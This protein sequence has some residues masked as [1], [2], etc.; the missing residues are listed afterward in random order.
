[1]KLTLEVYSTSAGDAGGAPS[2]GVRIRDR[3][4]LEAGALYDPLDVNFLVDNEFLPAPETVAV[5]IYRPSEGGEDALVATTAGSA[6]APVPGHSMMR[7][8]ALATSTPGFDSWYEET[9]CPDGDHTYPVPVFS[10]LEVKWSC[11]TG[12][13][14]ARARAV[15]AILTPIG[16]RAVKGLDGEDGEDGKAPEVDVADLGDGTYRMTVTSPDGTVQTVEWRDG[17]DGDGAA[18][19]APVSPADATRDDQYADALAVQGLLAS[20]RKDLFGL[21]ARLDVIDSLA[22]VEL[23]ESISESLAAKVDKVDGSGLVPVG[24]ISVLADFI[25]RHGN[26]GKLASLD[27]VPFECLAASFAKRFEALEAAVESFPSSGEDGTLTP[28]YTKFLDTVVASGDDSAQRILDAVDLVLAESND[29]GK[30]IW[31]AVN[32]NAKGL[33]ELEAKVGSGGSSSIPAELEAMIRNSVQKDAFGRGFSSNDFTQDYIDRINNSVQKEPGKGLSTVDF[34]MERAER[35]DALFNSSSTLNPPVKPDENAKEG[36]P[37]DAKDTYEALK[38]KASPTTAS[39]SYGGPW[40]GFTVDI[41]PGHFASGYYRCTFTEDPTVT[42]GGSSWDVTGIKF[43]IEQAGGHTPAQGRL[44]TGDYSYLGSIA[45]SL[46][47]NATSIGNDFRLGIPSVD[48]PDVTFDVSFDISCS[49]ELYIRQGDPYVTKTYVDEKI[50]EEIGKIDT[51]GS[52][53]TC[54]DNLFSGSYNDL[55]EKPLI[56]GVE[57]VGGNNV[58][59]L[60]GNYVPLVEDK[61]GTYTTAAVGSLASGATV[62]KRGLS[63]G[64]SNT[65]GGN[66]ALVV[67]KGNEA[68]GTPC[69]CAGQNSY[70]GTLAFAFGES[71]SAKAS[72]S[73]AAGQS[74]TASSTHSVS[75]GQDNRSNGKW[76]FSAGYKCTA[77]YDSGM[78]LGVS[79]KTATHNQFVWNGNSSSEYSAPADKPGAFCVNP[80]LGVD[81][82]YVGDSTLG[83]IL[84]GKRDKDDC[85]ATVDSTVSMGWRFS[86]PVKEIEDALNDPVSGGKVNYVGNSSGNPERPSHV[87]ALIASS[88][89]NYVYIDAYID[90]DYTT[91]RYPETLV[92]NC[93]ISKE[94]YGS[95]WTHDALIQVTAHALYVTFV[96]AGET[97]VTPTGVKALTAP[98]FSQLAPETS[99]TEVV[100]KP[101]DGKANWVDQKITSLPGAVGSTVMY[102]EL[103]L[104]GD[105]R[106]S[107]GDI[108]DQ[109]DAREY[110]I[111]AQVFA[112]SFD[113]FDQGTPCVR[114][115]VR[116]DLT[117]KD[118]MGSDCFKFVKGR[119]AVLHVWG[120]EDDS[121]LHNTHTFIV[122]D[123]LSDLGSWVG[124]YA[125]EKDAEVSTANLTRYAEPYSVPGKSLSVSLPGSTGQA[126]SFSL[127]LA[128]D[129]EKETDVT[130]GGATGIV[131]AFPGASKLIPGEVV[132]DVKEVAPGKMLVNRAPGAAGGAVTITGDNGTVYTLGV[133]S[134]GTLEVRS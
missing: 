25:D 72:G 116:E 3:R 65:L 50:E 107:S 32:A 53:C 10:I 37:A 60:T 12:D 127:T 81:G 28:R 36:Q 62:G 61:S 80:L 42:W 83:G 88:T 45:T 119:S 117:V 21:E 91:S 112:V 70:A 18:F 77:A 27:E 75:F 8:G 131:E 22:G 59:P 96:K 4:A 30:G 48:D 104:S 87:F 64:E 54:G 98:G 128:T 82:F 5:S 39:D 52:D 66:N 35:L 49:R 124:A 99:D 24:H 69:V 132:W 41:S 16:V 2:F 33:V 29:A 106:S 100:L 58:I 115:E 20:L 134:E 74:N 79:A 105:V 46:D 73:F 95:D 97:F 114:V 6:F 68:A 57:L 38:G 14:T 109:L 56:N 89:E 17:R 103:E 67:G 84:S 26:F 9:K 129:A 7:R 13:C 76:A 1:M 11:G 121:F 31:K 23:L 120:H 133:D 40:G 123:C 93:F 43:R 101:V 15:P 92:F 111:P 44:A 113:S 71:C 125:S 86:C 55:G 78:A 94:D 34:T 122:A 118:Y 130:W 47:R 85:V 126:R 108:I 102:Y 19:P 63:V 51:G 110:G 90:S